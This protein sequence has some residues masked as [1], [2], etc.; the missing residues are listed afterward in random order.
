M[1]LI[2]RLETLWHSRMSTPLFSEAIADKTTA[3]QLALDDAF[4]E[5]AAHIKAQAARIT[6]LENLEV[7]NTEHDD[8]VFY[9]FRALTAKINN[10]KQC[11]YDEQEGIT[12]TLRNDRIAELEATIKA[13]AAKI[14]QLD[15]LCGAHRHSQL[16]S[17]YRI[18]ELEARL[19]THPQVSKELALKKC[20][21]D[22]WFNHHEDARFFNEA[23][24]ASP[25]LGKMAND[26]ALPV[27][28]T[29]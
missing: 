12:A 17:I 5:L 10:L 24:R 19:S 15:A 22:W 13:Q 23:M 8:L 25:S 27:E 6:R 11:L 21:I 14:E 9:K 3:L 16:L 1:E 2:E 29:G 28:V 18:A 4:P 7:A 20:F 26:A